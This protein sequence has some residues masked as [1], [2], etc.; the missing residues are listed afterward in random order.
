MGTKAGVIRVLESCQRLAQDIATGQLTGY[1]KRWERVVTSMAHDDQ[2]LLQMLYLEGKIIGD[3]ECRIFTNFGTADLKIANEDYELL[4]NKRLRVRATDATPQVIHFSGPA[5]T[6][7]RD[8]WAALL[9]VNGLLA[10]D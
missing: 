7:A 3:R 5:C 2:L 9:G 8:Q 10:L 1:A 6:T 4:T